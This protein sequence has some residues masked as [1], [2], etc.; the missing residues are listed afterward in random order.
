MPT[1]LYVDDQPT[2]LRAFVG[3]MRKHFGVLAAQSGPEGLE[4]LKKESVQVIVTDERMSPMRGIEFCKEAQKIAPE[5]PRIM[6]T[7]PISMR[8]FLENAINQGPLYG[9]FPK[10]LSMEQK[11]A[12]Y[13]NR[14]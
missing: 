7:R 11:A 6:L 2:S 14:K 12:G 5:V 1:V 9:F 4:I 10:S 3:F 8:S 13:E